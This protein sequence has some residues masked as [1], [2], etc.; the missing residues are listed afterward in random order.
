MIEICT[1]FAKFKTANQRLTDQVRTIIKKCW[2]SDHK[3]LELTQQ[4]YRETY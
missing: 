3:I 1:D 2:F 4:I